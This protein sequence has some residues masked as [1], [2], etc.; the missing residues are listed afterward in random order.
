MLTR[1][2]QAICLRNKEVSVTCH[3]FSRLRSI[4][5]LLLTVTLVACIDLSE[6][7][8]FAD[9]SAGANVSFPALVS[10]IQ[11]SCQRRASFAPDSQRTI[12][13]AG[14]K[15]FE[16]SR[17]SLL[18]AQQVLLDY[19]EALKNLSS[20]E[21]VT[22]GNKLDA[23]PDALSKSG[24]DDQQVRAA[25]GL[26]KKIADAAL[27]GYRRKEL[28][29]LVGEA[30]GDVQAVTGAL[31]TIVT[32]DYEREL[33]LEEEGAAAFYRTNLQE[34][35]NVEPLT[36]ILVERA[37]AADEREISDKQK[38][39]EAYGK[40]MDSIAQGHQKL[41]DNRSTWSTTSLLKELGP[42]VQDLYDSARDVHKAFK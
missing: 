31:K 25:T 14:C 34:H 8:K 32:K 23:L 29:R 12:S 1:L 39:A 18:Q 24:F 2:T 22:Y 41:Y 30:N 28:S 4:P 26:A 7:G 27:S 20:N 5:L 21:S 6:V 15:N 33:N 19:M 38:A 40:V 17:E 13:L 16:S 3:A 37:W 36:K 10:D 11:A 42:I 9:I 35:G